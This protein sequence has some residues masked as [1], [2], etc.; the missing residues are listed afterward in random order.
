M[1]TIQSERDPQSR[2]AVQAAG[3]TGPRDHTS[4]RLGAFYYVGRNALNIGGTL[5]PDLPT[6][7]DPFYRVGGDFRFKYRKFE[8][9][10][11]GM[12][13]H[14]D[15]QLV[16]GETSDVLTAG[17]PV[18][19]SGG[20]A[21]GEYW[22]YPWLI[23][24]AARTAQGQYQNCSENALESSGNKITSRAPGSASTRPP[25]PRPAP[26]SAP[27]GKPCRASCR[28]AGRCR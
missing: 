26:R 7:R 18:N 22:F 6:I 5:Y 16:T 25:G 27:A 21:Q 4:L 28:T 8:L 11:L 20:F 23:G 10:G 13:G 14:D 24:T 12:Y 15:N 3:A 9:Y 2:N 1:E 17:P 19:F